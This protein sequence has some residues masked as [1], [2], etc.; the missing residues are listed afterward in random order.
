MAKLSNRH[1]R[2]AVLVLTLILTV[3]L[4]AV[5]IALA[6][7]VTVGLRTSKVTDA[8][9]QTNAD[10]AAAVTWA[11][12]GFRTSSRTMSSCTGLSNVETVPN[13]VAVNGSAVTLQCEVTAPSGAFPVVH[14]V[15]IATR[16]NVRRNVEAVAQVAPGVAVRALDWKIDD[17][18]LVNP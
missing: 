8:R 7:F 9:S 15:A 3:V 10:A 17:S 2:G 6:G 14:L 16:N 1:D 13:A 12:E 11:M 18:Q 4:A 5:V